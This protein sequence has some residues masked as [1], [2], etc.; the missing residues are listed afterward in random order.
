MVSR[1]SFLRASIPL[2]AGLAGCGSTSND[3]QPTATATTASPPS[4][5]YFASVIDQADE[6]R[7]LTVRVGVENESERELRLAPGGRSRPLEDL[8]RFEG[9][10]ELIL[11]PTGGTGVTG[12]NL[13]DDPV[14]G[15][16]RFVDAEGE[17]TSKAA[18]STSVPTTIPAGFRY[19]VRHH[20]YQVADADPCLP[21]GSYRSSHTL[22]VGYRRSDQEFPVEFVVTIDE[23]GTAS[24]RAVT[25]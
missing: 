24:M 6:H 20:V 2:T 25:A 19:T 3:E 9:A 1:R 17:S 16:W 10:T 15:C 18:I 4:L 8:D 22:Y 21:Q 5:T 14:E 11:I 12:V 13:R 23:A 7:P